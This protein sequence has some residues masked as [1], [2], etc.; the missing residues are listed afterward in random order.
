M[1]KIIRKSRKHRSSITG[2]AVTKDYADANPDTT[3]TETVHKHGPQ[4]QSEAVEMIEY[5]LRR[6]KIFT[7]GIDNDGEPFEATGAAAGDDGVILLT[8]DGA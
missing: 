4:T 1:V 6:F 5:I 3:T 7:D 8:F 2:R